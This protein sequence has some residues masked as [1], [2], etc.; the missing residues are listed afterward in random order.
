MAHIAIGLT[1]DH[2]IYTM[3]YLSSGDVKDDLK[4][5]DKNSTNTNN[6][7]TN[8]YSD[9]VMINYVVFYFLWILFY[10]IINCHLHLIDY[11]WLVV[12]Q[13]HYMYL[14]RKNLVLKGFVGGMLY[15]SYLISYRDDIINDVINLFLL[16]ESK[17]FMEYNFNYHN[18]L[19]DYLNQYYHLVAI[20]CLSKNDHEG[21]SGSSINC[22]IVT[23]SN[24]HLLLAPGS[25]GDGRHNNNNNTI[26][27][28][29]GDD[30]DFI[31]RVIADFVS[32]NSGEHQ[33][34]NLLSNTDSH[35]PA[36]YIS[37]YDYTLTNIDIN[38]SHKNN[39][40]KNNNNNN[41]NNNDNHDNSNLKMV[42]KIIF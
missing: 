27:N 42:I 10:H 7:D 14:T 18:A 26:L 9:L 33:L 19:S 1:N 4:I 23:E 15:H 30:H 40:D 29:D 36:R 21:N 5:I 22:K 24:D 16:V 34:A 12:C 28:K 25:D 17:P 13:L 11:L 35:I 3:E 38:S 32:G 20:I 31:P 6:L 39:N 2:S 8:V 37:S 41:N